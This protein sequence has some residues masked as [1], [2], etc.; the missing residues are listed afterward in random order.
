[1]LESEIIIASTDARSR[2]PQIRR[3]LGAVLGLPSPDDPGEVIARRPNGKPVPPAMAAMLTEFVGII[4]AGD[5]TSLRRFIGAHFAAD[6]GGP[7][8]ND[9]IQRLGNMHDNLG[10]LRVERIE[11]FDDGPFELTLMSSVEGVV[12]VRVMADHAEPY[13]IHGLQFRIGG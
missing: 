9:R 1:M 11:A 6:P 12:N 13:R 5:T 10:A 2:A 7:T 3:A 8:T 4:N